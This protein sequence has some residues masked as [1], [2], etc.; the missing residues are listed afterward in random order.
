MSKYPKDLYFASDVSETGESLWI[1]DGRW[2]V[3]ASAD[4]SFVPPFEGG[5]AIRRRIAIVFNGHFEILRVFRILN[6]YSFENRAPPM[7]L[8]L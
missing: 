1:T 8:N 2:P 4:L 3:F 5:V 6:R 7:P